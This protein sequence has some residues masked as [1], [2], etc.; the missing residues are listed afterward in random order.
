MLDAFLL[1]LLACP[2]CGAPGLEIEETQRPSGAPAAG[3]LYCQVCGARYPLEGGIPDL[4]PD[5]IL[6]GPA[7]TRWQGHLKGLASRREAR[8]RG[9]FVSGLGRSDLNLRAFSAFLGPTEGLVLDVGCGTG[10]LRDY[11]SPGFR[12]VGVDPLPLRG[13]EHFPFCRAVAERLPFRD[14]IFD[15]VAAVATLDHVNDLDRALRQI[16]RV[17]RPGGRFHVLQSLHEIRGPASALR[18]LAHALKDRLEEHAVPAPAPGVPKHMAEF[19][20]DSLRAA[21]AGPFRMVAERRFG[22]HWY[23]PRLLFATLRLAAEASP[24]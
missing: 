15:H 2:T 6:D 4:V 23:Y 14:G 22:A 19:T 1:D 12:Y 17:L 9:H 8:G 11:L 21:L 10:R 24:E 5:G 3:S 16:A 7:W 20:G 13:V 18:C